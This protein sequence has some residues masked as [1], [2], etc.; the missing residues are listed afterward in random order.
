VTTPLIPA[1]IK[2]GE[3]P[4]AALPVAFERER[5]PPP[6]PFYVTKDDQIL[7]QV[8]NSS[9]GLQFFARGR[10]ILLTGEI[11]TFEYTSSP[12]SDRLQN[13]FTIPLGDGWLLN[14]VMTFGTGGS[15]R[16]ATYVIATLLRPTQG[17][18]ATLATFCM[19]YIGG[20]MVLTWPSGRLENPTDGR[21]L[22]RV[23]T[24]TTPGAGADISESCPSNTRWTLWAARWTFT[25]SA[26][27]GNRLVSLRLDD[28]GSGW[29]A[30]Y[31]SSAVQAV[32]TTV[33]YDAANLGAVNAPVGADSLIL[34]P[35][36]WPM[37]Q[38]HRFRSDT[39]GL[40]AADQY[41]APIY[42]V[43]ELLEP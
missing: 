3:P 13:R 33:S 11:K 29:L 18:S 24:G 5:V 37:F 2:P 35:F 40:G 30:R 31:P 41:T 28:G 34:A 4:I 36:P 14:L 27:G 39:L 17:A 42:L 26:A 10:L 9:P 43:E 20:A 15:R 7:V 25:T 6:A 1:L 32:S 22:L 19:G 21:G 38:G 8:F 12:T 16:G 23:I